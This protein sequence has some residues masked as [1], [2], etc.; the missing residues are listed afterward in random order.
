VVKST[1]DLLDLDLTRLFLTDGLDEYISEPLLSKSV[2]LK[3][4][5]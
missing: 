4:G 5:D 1:E 3:L 2:A